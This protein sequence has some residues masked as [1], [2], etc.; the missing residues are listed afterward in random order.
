MD[1]MDENKVVPVY[2]FADGQE[3]LEPIKRKIRKTME[4]TEEFTAWDVLQYVA[5][6]EK[7]ISTKEAE[8]EGLKNMKEAF[9]K[10]MV[11]VEEQTSVTSMQEEYQKT[12]AE[13]INHDNEVTS[14]DKKEG[15]VESPYTKEVKPE[16]TNGETNV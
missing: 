5:N 16:E 2:T 15:E 13:N 4:V 10:E 3:N 12:V 1:I 8:L 11:H 9:L 14:M 7:Q 6:M